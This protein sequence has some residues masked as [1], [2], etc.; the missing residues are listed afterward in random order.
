MK[1]F[2][3]NALQSLVPQH[4]LTQFAGKLA[5]A[6]TPWFKNF[7]IHR[8]MK[9]Y[10]IDLSEAVIQSPEDF[11]SFNDFFIRQLQPAARPICDGSREI[12]SPVDGSVAQIGTIAINQLLQ[13]KG[14]LFDLEAL[15]GGDHELAEKFYDGSFAT[16]YLA[17]SNYHRIHMP[18]DGTL[19]QSIY[20]PGKLFS[21]NTKTTDVVPN[22]FSRNERLITVFDTPAG[23]MAVILVGAMI[24]GSIQTTWMAEPIRGKQITREVV[25]TDASFEKGDELGFFKLGSTV[26]L[27]FEK[28]RIQWNSAFQPGSPIQMGQCLAAM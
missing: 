13:A 5:N 22:L 19:T 26:I 4:L 3:L 7:L 18:L 11:A 20:V 27:L 25:P 24:V 6:K 28:D 1:C 2:N 9:T 21:V 14:F 23:K 16:L 17:P 8:F 12:A 10:N 15:L